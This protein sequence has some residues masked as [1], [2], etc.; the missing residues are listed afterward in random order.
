MATLNLAAVLEHP[1]RLTP[2]RV[3]MT[4][5]SDHVTYAELNAKA[6]RLAAGLHAIGVRAGDHVALSC[7]NLPVFPIVYF[8]ILKAGAAV[9]PINVLLKTREIAYHLRDSG[10]KA[11][12][13]F[14]GTP[15]LPIAD[16]VK[17]ACAEA[18]CPHFI[19]IPTELAG[20]MRSDPG[21]H[22]PRREPHDTAV[23]LYTS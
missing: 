13:A 7:P 12:I 9:V 16:M 11:A 4:F 17:A 5:G 2:E 19:P 8:G 3:A 1:A 6:D 18:K 21:F 15:E 20:L 22:S 10:A 14:D 23:I